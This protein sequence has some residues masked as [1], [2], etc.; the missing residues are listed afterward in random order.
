MEKALNQKICPEAL[1][2]KILSTNGTYDYG[3]TLIA[4]YNFYDSDGDIEGNSAI[5]WYADASKV[6]SENT[7]KVG[8][9]TEEKNK[10]FY[11]S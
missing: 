6:S 2:V 5:A 4:S 9:I 8:A 7:F 10:I 11:N 1:D 3:D